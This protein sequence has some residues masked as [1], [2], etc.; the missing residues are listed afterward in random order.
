MHLR[1]TLIK[2]K[3]VNDWKQE[4]L[5]AKRQLHEEVLA[6]ENPA[7][8]SEDAN[9]SGLELGLSGGVGGEDGMNGKPEGVVVSER[10][11]AL[12][13]QRIAKW[14]AE[15]AAKKEEEKV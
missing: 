7:G 8:S 15:Q 12:A 11:R 5:T 6:G 2:K 3:A 13:K 1:L 14:K 10:E 4:Q 9:R